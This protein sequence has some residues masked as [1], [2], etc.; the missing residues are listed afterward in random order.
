M[1]I[2]NGKAIADEIKDKLR[3]SN[4]NA[5]I[6]PCLAILNIGDDRENLLYI[7][8]KKK[9]VDAIG[10]TTHSIFLPREVKRE[11]L[12]EQIQD[13]NQDKEVHGILLQLPLSD[14][15]E[16]YREDFLETIAAHK[17]VDGF[18]PTNRGKLMGAE[19]LFISCAALA[20]MDI[21]Q[22]YVSPLKDKKI[23]LVGNSFDVIQPLAL[24]FVKEACE[25]SI[26]PQYY[27]EAM[28]N[29]DI[30]I[31]EK[32]TP[33][34]VGAQYIKEGCLL[35]DAGF[36]WYQERTCGNVD[37]TAVAGVGGYLLPVPGGMGPLLIAHLMV[38][39]SHA[40]RRE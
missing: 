40:A 35:I 27:P 8:L 21:C 16:P 29:I 25:V 32:G 28:E 15:L 14:N 34:A 2:I 10:G 36:H 9:S 38:N 19:P 12:L 7:D 4:N 3:E 17:D 30:A 13:L 11:Q 18:C 1:E 39:L 24:M 26:I 33:L 20:C 31:I 23:L 22:R 6:S 5:G 37:R